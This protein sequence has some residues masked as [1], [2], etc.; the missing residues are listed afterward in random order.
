MTATT[1]ENNKTDLKNDVFQ[2]SKAEVELIMT[3]RSIDFG[4]IEG[5]TIKNGSPIEYKRARKLVKI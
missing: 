3:L 4:E 1:Y 2:L 5:L